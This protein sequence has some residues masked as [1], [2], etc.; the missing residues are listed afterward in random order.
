VPVVSSF[1][2]LSPGTSYLALGLGVDFLATFL[3]GGLSSSDSSSS[4]SLESSSSLS[5]FC[6]GFFAGCYFL[7]GVGLSY[8]LLLSC[9][10]P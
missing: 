6:E 5:S 8:S 10:S 4:S 1:I 2:Y 9:S 7:A 3:G